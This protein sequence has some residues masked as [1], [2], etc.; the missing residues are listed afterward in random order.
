MR[1]YGWESR[2]IEVAR[3]WPT[4]GPIYD[5]FN[6]WSDYSQSKWLFLFFVTMLSLKI[7]WRKLITPGILGIIAVTLGDL[8]SRRVLKAFILRPRP[9]FVDVACEVSK[10]WG[11]VSSHSTNVAAVAT[12]MCLYD[13]RNLYW[14]I[15]V[16]LL[17]GFSRIYLID[18]F[19][20]DVIG[21]MLLG[22][23]IGMI[24]FACFKYFKNRTQGYELERKS[25][26]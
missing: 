10:C 25:L 19:P 8:V 3:T 7:G 11:F 9:N 24:V 4:H 23:V 15:P 13:K 18:H 12:V 6:F 5:F 21:G 26:V 2:V 14:T 1:I 22:V 17:V 16:V 20:L